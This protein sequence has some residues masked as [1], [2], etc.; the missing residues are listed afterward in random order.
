[1]NLSGPTSFAPLIYK[2]IEIIK[3]NQLNLINRQKNKSDQSPTV[4]SLKN[5]YHIL[6]IIA[7]GKVSNENEAETVKAIIEASSYPL[8]VV[9]IGVGDG[10]WDTMIKFDDY[11]GSVSKF[12]NLQFVDYHQTIKSSKSPDYEFALKA[13]MEIPDQIKI[14]K[15]LNYL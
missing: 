4:N 2:S 7:D 1:M 13:L 15:K 9:V 8:S 11:L 5:P 3:Q 10:P 14:M 6:F 12:D